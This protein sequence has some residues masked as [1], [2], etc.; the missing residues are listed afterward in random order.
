MNIQKILS[1]PVPGSGGGGGASA[2][3]ISSA[4]GS[5]PSAPKFNIVGDSGTNQL[6]SS[7]GGA[8]KQNPVQA[9]VVAS[10]V[11]SAQSLNR[12]IIQNASLG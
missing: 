3:S 9:Y 12:N 2:P 1:V 7:L 6:A 10:D 5:T 11:S 4:S 8:L